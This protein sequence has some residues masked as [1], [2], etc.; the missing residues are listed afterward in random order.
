[1]HRM[2][3]RTRTEIIRDI[4]QTARSA[5]NGAG[6]T[7]L[8][9]NAFL[10][11]RQIGEYLTILFDSDLLQY[12]FDTRRF[13]ITEKGHSFL[14]LCYQIGDLIEVEEEGNNNG[15]GNAGEG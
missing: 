8:M 3:Y 9:Y 7:Q 2:K 6:K 13:R 12:D 4:L 11:Y 5:G 14:Q 10:S 15:N 1:M